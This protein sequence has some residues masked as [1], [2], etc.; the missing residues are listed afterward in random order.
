MKITMNPNEQVVKAG[1]STLLDNGSSV[2]GKLILTTQRIYFNAEPNGSEHEDIEIYPKDIRDVMLFK[3]RMFF[4]KGLSI[5]TNDDR[6]NRFL[7]NKR[8][9]WSKMIVRM[10]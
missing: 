2:T 7:I 9:E 5:I 4:P 1:D 3:D 8:E 6:E 10:V